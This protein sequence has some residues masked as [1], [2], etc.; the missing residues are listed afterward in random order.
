[1]ERDV[2]VGFML[3]CVSFQ[4]FKVDLGIEFGDLLEGMTVLSRNFCFGRKPRQG[5][6]SRRLTREGRRTEHFEL[7][8]TRE[9][10][11]R[12]IKLKS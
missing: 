3:C 2:E 8:I 6:S 4:H 1:M 9:T 7:Q 10:I 11:N 12:A 5:Y